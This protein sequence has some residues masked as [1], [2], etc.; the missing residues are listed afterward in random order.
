MR[1][2]IEP[3]C[4]A[5]K[6]HDCVPAMP[7]ACTVLSASSFIARAAAAA[8]AYTPTVAPECQPCAIC[9]GPMQMPTRGPI[10]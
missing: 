9:S 3:N 2:T 8:D 4:A 5:I 7:N 6:P 1:L 10:S